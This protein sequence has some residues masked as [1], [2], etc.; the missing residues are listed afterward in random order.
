MSYVGS[1]ASR[2]FQVVSGV[3]VVLCLLSACG[4]SDDPI[5]RAKELSTDAFET[6]RRQGVD[7]MRTPCIYYPNTPSG[8]N[9]WFAFVVFP[10]DGS[11]RE[12]ARKCPG[13][14]TLGYVALNQSGEVIEVEGV[15][16]DWQGIER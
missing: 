13:G 14:E 2:A 5:E 1:T 9:S 16:R 10:S 15:P 7:L 12:A 8:E 4:G 11:P 6:A 3:L